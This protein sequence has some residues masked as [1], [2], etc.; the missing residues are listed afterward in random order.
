MGL[1]DM[2][3][4]A[5]M[6][7]TVCLTFGFVYPP[8]ALLGVVSS[9]AMWRGRELVVRR[10]LAQGL[11]WHGNWLRAEGAGPP[12]GLSLC[13]CGGMVLLGVGLVFSAK[14]VSEGQVQNI[15]PVVSMAVCLSACAAWHWRRQITCTWAATEKSEG[16][17]VSAAGAATA[18]ATGA[19]D[20]SAE[21]SALAAS[22]AE[23]REMETIGGTD[24][25]DEQGAEG[26][27]RGD[28]D[29]GEKETGE[30][31]EKTYAQIT[32]PLLSS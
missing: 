8:V 27:G 32:E 16:T 11:H 23:H 18:T 5:F 25:E 2:Y 3:L 4:D 15:G 1:G 28:V 26:K 13:M 19:W 21:L 20:V 9:A 22:L 12:S 31:N 24:C 6:C 10:K 17:L 14:A 29:A 30:S 7:V